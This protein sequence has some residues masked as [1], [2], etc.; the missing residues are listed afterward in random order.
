MRGK[1]NPYYFR[2]ADRVTIGPKMGRCSDRISQIISVRRNPTMRLRFLVLVAGFLIFFPIDGV[3]TSEAGLVDWRLEARDDGWYAVWISN[4]EV[5]HKLQSL[6]TAPVLRLWK[7]LTQRPNIGLLFYVTGKAEAGQTAHE[8]RAI[9]VETERRFVL[10]DVSHELEDIIGASLP[11]SHWTWR[12]TVLEVRDPADEHLERIRLEPPY[13]EDYP[14][15]P[16]GDYTPAVTILNEEKLWSFQ[17]EE[18]QEELDR[19]PNFAGH[20][21]LIRSHCGTNCTIPAILDLRS[22]RVTELPFGVHVHF[23]ETAPSIEFRRDSRLLI[24]HGSLNEVTDHG[25]HFFVWEDGQLLSP[26]Y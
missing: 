24:A 16:V 26:S 18:V 25:P 19:Q 20:H 17:R 2:M 3:Q 13:F 10:G 21:R 1:R 4:P 8:H 14:A 11:H 22:G 12:E 7:P 6:G 9:I 15:L 5:T 23:Y